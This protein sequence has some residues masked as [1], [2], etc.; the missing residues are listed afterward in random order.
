MHWVRQS[1]FNIDQK[2]LGNRIQFELDSVN[3]TANFPAHKARTFFGFDAFSVTKHI[4]VNTIEVF[5]KWK[6]WVKEGNVVDHSNEADANT[7]GCDYKESVNIIQ[8]VVS[9]IEVKS[10]QKNSQ[11]KRFNIG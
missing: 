6:R 1:V 7:T 8:E 9:E 4:F 11:V 3:A 2:N 5:K 10:N